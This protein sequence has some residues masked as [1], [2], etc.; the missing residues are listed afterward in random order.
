MMK[1]ADD[2]WANPTER[3]KEENVRMIKKERRTEFDAGQMEMAR[4]GEL[5]QDGERSF[6]RSWPCNRPFWLLTLKWRR[7]DWTLP[8]QINQTT[9]YNLDRFANTTNHDQDLALAF[10]NRIV[11][12][13][14]RTIQSDRLLFNVKIHS[15]A[16]LH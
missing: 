14:E 16:R 3:S 10:F 5:V 15:F 7:E 4:A 12:P 8:A 2:A 6:I 11:W 13:S 9:I 1:K